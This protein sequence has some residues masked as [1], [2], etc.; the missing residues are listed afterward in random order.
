MF[1]KAKTPE[2]REEEKRKKVTHVDEN[3]TKLIQEKLSKTII[4]T[5]IRVISS[6]STL[7]R[8]QAI[9]ADLES[10]FAQFAEVNGNSIKWEEVEGKKQKALLHR[11]S[12][13]LWNEDESYPLNLS[14]LASLFHFPMQTKDVANVRDAT[15]SQSPAP[16]DLCTEG[17]V[18]GVNKNR[19]VET[20]V[21][22]GKEDRMRHMYVLGQTGTGKTVFMKRMIIQ[23]IENGDGCCF[24]D[25][26]GSDIVDILANIPAHRAKDVIYFDPAYMPSYGS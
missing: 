13:R 4:E 8:T 16:Q 2:E 5:N 7:A 10:A 19:G 3:A 18:I 17:V 11:Y 14:E 21:H 25:P 9:R 26:H 6:A 20:V 22:F 24:I 12:Y 23:D 1:D 15:Y